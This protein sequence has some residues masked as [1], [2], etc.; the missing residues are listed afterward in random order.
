MMVRI[1]RLR[2]SIRFAHRPAP[3]RMTTENRAFVEQIRATGG[4]ARTRLLLMELHQPRTTGHLRLMEFIT[5]SLA[6]V[7]G[8]GV[9]RLRRSLRSPTCSA[10]DDKITARARVFRFAPDD[11]GLNKKTHP[12]AGYSN[13]LEW[14]KAQGFRNLSL[15][16]VAGD[17]S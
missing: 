9:L 3:L 13:V 5:D 1:L 17:L 6:V 7:K 4:E 15:V 14:K 10:Q 2:R 11:R 12:T 8:I 16:S